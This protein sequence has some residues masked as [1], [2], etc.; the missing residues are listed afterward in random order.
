MN[1]IPC[2]LCDKETALTN[3]E[4]K[5]INNGSWKQLERD[6]FASIHRGKKKTLFQIINDCTNLISNES[7]L[8]QGL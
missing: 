4:R 7:C 6:Y 5:P 1:T 2:N 3:A 8:N